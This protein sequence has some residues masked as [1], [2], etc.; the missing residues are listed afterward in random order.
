MPL[1]QEKLMDFLK[2]VDSRL[3]TTV[4]VTAVGGT[5]MTL[6]GI[7]SSTIDID[8]NADEEAYGV[9]KEALGSMP[10]GYRIDLYSNGLIFSQQLPDDYVDKRL[11][12]ET[13][14]KKLGLYAL[15][16]I[17][18]VAT[19]IGRLNERDIEDIKSCISKYHLTKKGI[20]LRAEQTE[21]VGRR[22]NYESNLKYVLEKL[23]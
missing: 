23:F 19:K 14:F 3:G 17:D 12:I 1:D 18:I 2:T 7:K 9:F 8:F 10:H 13:S 15:H 4:E 22:E 6:L 21:Y 5:A 20:S 11:P 16:P